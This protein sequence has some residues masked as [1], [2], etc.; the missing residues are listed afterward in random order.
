MEKRFISVIIFITLIDLFLIFIVGVD[1]EEIYAP[2]PEYF[3]EVEAKIVKRDNSDYSAKSTKSDLYLEYEFEEN[4]YEGIIKEYDG[5]TGNIFHLYI[6][7]ND[8]SYYIENKSK[9]YPYYSYSIVFCSFIVLFSIFD[10]ILIIQLVKY[11]KK[12]RTNE[13]TNIRNMY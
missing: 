9:M 1:L 8:P 6:D 13:V 2:V 10:I 11:K 12:I 3:V 4:I 5:I 7:K